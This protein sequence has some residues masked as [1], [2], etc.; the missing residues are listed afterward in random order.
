MDEVLQENL[1]QTDLP[2]LYFKSKNKLF[3]VATFLSLP[4]NEKNLERY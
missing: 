2:Q 4:F 1:G 3:C